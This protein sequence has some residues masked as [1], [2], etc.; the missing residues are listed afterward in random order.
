MLWFLENVLIPKK[1][2]GP[3]KCLCEEKHNGSEKTV[4]VFK[5]YFGEKTV[6]FPKN[7]MASPPPTI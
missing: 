2:F 4:L 5:K 6:R 1:V 3:Q 7:I